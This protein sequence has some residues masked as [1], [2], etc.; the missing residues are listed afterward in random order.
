[1]T[2]MNRDPIITV[3]GANVDLGDVLPDRAREAIV[4][5]AKKYVGR[6][7]VAA[8]YFNRVGPSYRSTVDI[9]VRWVPQ[10]KQLGP[11]LRDRS[12]HRPSPLPVLG[13][14]SEL[15]PGRR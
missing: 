11:G 7:S 9:L 2:S 1:M 3:E 4:Q 8:V 5:V 15:T 14:S 13:F 10:G 6:L 12:C